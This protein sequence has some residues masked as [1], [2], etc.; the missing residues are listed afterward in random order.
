MKRLAFLIAVWSSLVA[1]ADERVISYDDNVRTPASGDVLFHDGTSWVL[2]PKGSNGHALTL[3]LGLP[4]WSAID[5]DFV[6]FDDGDGLWTATTVGSALEE[7]ND[8]INAGS[9]NGTGSKLHWS[10]LLGVP[11]GFADGTDDG[12]GGGSG[13]VTSVALSTPGIFSVSGSPVT[14]SGTLAFAVVNQDAN[15]IWAG[16]TSGAAAAPSFRALSDNDIPSGITRD[17]EVA[18]GYQPLDADLTD[19]ADG[20]LTGSKVGSGVDGGNITTGTVADARID[21]A[22][23]RDS[24]VSAAYQPSDADLTDLADG[25]LTG[26]KVGSGIDGGN[27]TTGTVADARIDASIA[28]D[29]EVSAA[30]QPLD[31]DLTDLADG[32][33][34]GSKI[35][36]GID[37]DN[38]SFD[39]GDSLW[40]AT[41]V[42]AALEE[43]N[44]S[45]N[46]GVPNGTGAK[47]HWSQLLGVPS[48]FSDG[49]DDGAGG[50]GATTNARIWSWT[51]ADMVPGTNATTQAQ[52][53]VLGDGIPTLEFDGTTGEEISMIGTW[54]RDAA[55]TSYAL[56]SF[57]SDDAVATNTVC[58]EIKL[59]SLSL[60]GIDTNLWTTAYTWTSNIP[61]TA[62]VPTNIIVPIAS[63]PLSS[64]GTNDWGKPYM[65]RVSRLPGSDNS[66]SN[67]YLLSVDHRFVP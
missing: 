67:A 20:S 26:S 25:T 13:T 5:D 51:A 17:S 24:E 52:F 34:T 65:M 10:Q 1:T 2:L 61:G 16:P 36:S 29:S 35:G 63:A 55:S 14:V 59:Q 41:T 30:Y 40:T 37:D 56:L 54:P 8:S 57:A 12:A 38:V 66:S 15:T 33:L 11:A 39:D 42:G 58:W 27:I 48:G 32:S 31:A 28:R 7:L 21:A 23:A 47:V 50:G 46:A 6:A 9:P 43:L 45:I 62:R 60:R 19:L 22:L 53:K 18:A 3:V 4:L 64:G 49:T 44:D